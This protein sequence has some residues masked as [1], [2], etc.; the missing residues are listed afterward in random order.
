[1]K[2]VH[3]LSNLFHFIYSLLVCGICGWGEGRGGLL[4]GSRMDVESVWLAQK[5]VEFKRLILRR[6]KIWGRVEITR[7]TFY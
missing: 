5:W 3:L 6:L 7:Q 4:R 1:M 2:S